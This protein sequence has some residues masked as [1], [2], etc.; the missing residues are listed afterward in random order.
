MRA[1]QLSAVHQL[2]ITEVPDP[3]P[4]GGEVLIALRTAALNHRDV[5]IKSG[6]Y[7]GLK[8]PCV[9]GSDGAGEVI[10][11]GAGSDPSW[12]GRPVIINPSFGWGERTNAQGPDFSILGLPRQGTLAE[13]IAVP[14]TQISEKPADLSW[15]EA[16]ALPLGGLTA[17]R[18]LFSRAG[19]RA[20][21]RLLIS[22]IGGGVA[23]LGLQLALGAGADV[24]V[25]SS[26]ADKIERAVK[27]GAKGGFN[28]RDPEWTAA[29]LKC[30]G[31]F[32]VV[33]DSAAGEGFAKLIDVTASGGRIVFY[34]ATRGDTPLPVRKIFWRQISLLG[35]TMGSPENWKALMAFVAERKVKPIISDVFPM[36]R[37]G[38]AFALMERGEQ[39]GKIV[40][41][42]G[43]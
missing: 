13:K 23:L 5:W 40:V 33:L 25:T 9:P 32:D 36:D 41:R 27:L 18:A 2:A 8:W 39:F 1:V 12:M 10:A 7:A 29:A 4:A 22:G 11:V 26:S 42:V 20:G 21:E 31:Q 16:A 3:V 34:G 17:Y 28:Y 24:W 43:S 30:P 19:L 38:E 37:A 6:Q 15:E 35:S 14:A